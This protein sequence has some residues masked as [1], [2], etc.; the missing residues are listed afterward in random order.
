MTKSLLLF[1]PETLPE[2]LPLFPLP[3][4]ILLPRRRLP[5]SI[6]EPRYIAM[7]EDALA[8][9][10]IIG[11]I[12]PT[13]LKPIDAPPL[14]RVGGAGRITAFEET[15]D[16]RFV[17]TLTGLCRFAVVSESPEQR[18]YRC[19]V[20]DW[21]SFQ[22]DFEQESDVV[23]LDRPRLISSLRV[24]FREQGMAANWEAI[25]E[26][27]DEPLISCLAMICPFDAGEK[28]ALLEAPSMVERF[29]LLLA[30][31]EMAVASRSDR[32]VSVVRH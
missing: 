28:Q 26:T 24:Y 21:S 25:E 23:G 20:P 5:L 22:D 2:L 29:Q 31:L 15:P 8:G 1:R 30:L 11:M 10:R 3:G 17:I 19:A 27:P 16:G 14:Y 4:V 12:Q 32:R 18:G 7:V 6:F 13:G 9:Q